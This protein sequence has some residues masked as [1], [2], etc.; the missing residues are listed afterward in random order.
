MAVLQDSPPTQLEGDAGAAPPPP[1]S[2][3]DFSQPGPW[4]C[5][6]W[7]AAFS[8][9][10]E[11]RG[12][13][14]ARL[15][16]TVTLPD[17]GTALPPPPPPASPFGPGACLLL[18]NGFQARAPPCEGVTPLPD[19]SRPPPLASP[20]GARG[21]VPSLGGAGGGGGAR[22]G[23]VRPA[24]AAHGHD[25]CRDAPLPAAGRVARGA[26]RRPRLPAAR[27]RGLRA[28][29][30]GGAQPRRQA[31]RAAVCGQPWGARS[32]GLPAG[33]RWA[34]VTGCA[35]A[36]RASCVCV[37]GWRLPLPPHTSKR[38]LPACLLSAPPQSMR[39]SLRQSRPTSPQRPRRS[40]AA[41]V[42]WA[43]P[44]RA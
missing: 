19:R 9:P 36:W 31:G 41:G 28:P 43:S 17:V 29:A 20:P 35:L 16:V 38:C 25:C 5:T 42:R 11:L 3:A 30:A 23:A 24:A 34:L 44:A 15:G 32:R 27:A 18:F 14:A 26:R 22:G 2:A 21:G 33:R 40:R 39:P 6:T 10:P 8:V 12:A 1:T 37:G 7:R 13:I 4:A